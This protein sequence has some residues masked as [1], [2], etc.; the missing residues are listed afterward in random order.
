[1]FGSRSASSTTST[2]SSRMSAFCTLRSACLRS[3]LVAVKPGVPRR[4]RK[5]LTWSSAVSRAQMTT[6]SANVALPIQRLA[7]LSTHVSPVRC[8]VVRRPRA[9]SEP[10]SGSVRPK[11]PIDLAGGHGREPLGALLG[12][13]ADADRAHRQPVLHADEG[14]EAGVDARELERD[15]PAVERGVLEALGLGPHRPEHAEPADLGDEV[16]RELG[17]VPVVVG[18]RA[19][20]AL[21]ELPDLHDVRVL[22]RGE[23]VL[24]RVEVARQEGVG[25]V[26]LGHV[27]ELRSSIGSDL[28]S[29]VCIIFQ[30]VA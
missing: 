29:R 20:L 23:E 3:I 27:D 19:Q 22:V 9:V 28:T 18:D 5:P 1:M 13:A 7:P 15:P 11:P 21:Q 14:R 2:P 30:D 24:E 10:D 4:T 16:H 8:A 25:Q 6:T 17:A 26:C 12:G